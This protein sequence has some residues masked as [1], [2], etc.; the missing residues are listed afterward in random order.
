MKRLG[1]REVGPHKRVYDEFLEQG[2]RLVWFR[3]SCEDC[4][5][6]WPE[7]GVYPPECTQEDDHEA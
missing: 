2:K 5:V 1:P 7:G 3:T 6:G 4:G